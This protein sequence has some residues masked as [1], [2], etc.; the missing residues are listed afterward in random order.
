MREGIDAQK[1]IYLAERFK[2]LGIDLSEK[3]VNQF[4]IYANL[5]VEWNSV[6]N[7][8][9]ITKFEE[10][11]EK[12]FMDSV[13]VFLLLHVSRETICEEKEENSSQR[14][15]NILSGVSRET[16]AG[17][18]IDVGTGAGFPGIPL[19]IIFPDL[20]LTLLDSLNKRIR[21]LDEVILQLGLDHVQTVHG[22]AEET[23]HKKEYR[24][25]FDL[26]VS[27]AVANL[28]TL[29]E[30]CLPFLKVGGKFI[31]YKSGEIEEEIKNAEVAIST[32]G[33]E[34]AGRHFFTLPGTEIQRSLI[35]IRKEKA[36]AKKYPRK[37]GTP[38]RE[39]L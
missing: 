4:L 14:K 22:R 31:S 16:F 6:M 30:Y 17:K 18:M 9:A 29:S 21:F 25:Q 36:T 5:L 19:K 35:V 27:R 34:L 2:S 1:G 37:P 15:E 10:I 26:T 20:Q 12:H 13:A 23:A 3:Q 7:L 11:V 32:L 33:G 39:P 24:E 8:T 28:S 38:N